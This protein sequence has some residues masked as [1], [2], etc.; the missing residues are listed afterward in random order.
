MS[1][2]IAPLSRRAAS[3]RTALSVLLLAAPVAACGDN[4]SPAGGDDDVG[5]EP[6]AAPQ[7][8]SGVQGVAIEGLDGP[9]DVYFDEQGIMHAICQSDADCFAVEGYFHAAHRFAQMD[10]RRRFARGKLA[11]LVGP[12]GLDTDIAQR[13][14]MM[15]RDGTPLE[16][17][18]LAAAQPE[19]VA[20]LEAYS[21]GVNAWMDDVA[22]QRNGATL[23]DEYSF[24]FI[25]QEA[26]QDD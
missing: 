7:P 12:F 10:I 24:S 3:A 19:T 14:M 16:E 9:V 17:Q 18:L 20:A 2:P 26:I 1:S 6:D 21:R 8:D 22:S 15:A 13:Q 4:L 11:A 5:G 25:H 23:P